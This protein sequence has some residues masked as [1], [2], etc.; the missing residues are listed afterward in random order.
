MTVSFFLSIPYATPEK[1][2]RKMR[3]AK[4]LQF[5]IFLVLKMRVAPLLLV[6]CLKLFNSMVWSCKTDDDCP[7]G[8]YCDCPKEDSL[9]SPAFRNG[10]PISKAIKALTGTVSML[11]NS[12]GEVNADE[13]DEY[14]TGLLCSCRLIPGYDFSATEE[15]RD[16]H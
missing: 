8:A 11:M 7:V 12:L 10:L 1:H 15:V 13:N 5:A 6:I 2:L 4:Y 14:E 9:N 3:N 16:H